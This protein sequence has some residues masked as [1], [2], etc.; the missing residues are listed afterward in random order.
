MPI[1]TKKAKITQK[2]NKSQIN[3]KAVPNIKHRKLY[4]NR[5]IEQFLTGQVTHRARP[6]VLIDTA[7]IFYPGQSDP[8]N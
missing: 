6:F 7:S 5:K 8:S 1:L 4:K 2:K 3:L